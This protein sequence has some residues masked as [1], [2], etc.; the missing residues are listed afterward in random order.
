MLRIAFAFLLLA[1]CAPKP[2]DPEDT[3]RDGVVVRCRIAIV[4]CSEVN[5]PIC[6][7]IGPNVGWWALDYGAWV[8]GTFCDSTHH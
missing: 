2:L 6:H 7:E 5:E 4:Q 3:N 1:S 8:P